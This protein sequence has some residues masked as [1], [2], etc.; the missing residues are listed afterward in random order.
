M[1]SSI[2]VI[3]GF[4]SVALM[5]TSHLPALMYILSVSPYLPFFMFHFFNVTLYDFLSFHAS[6]DYLL[7]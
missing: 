3:D 7:P 2:H 1:T 6:I 5:D 4:L